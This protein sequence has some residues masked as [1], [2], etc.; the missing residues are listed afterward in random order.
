MFKFF[1]SKSITI[2]VLRLSGVIGQSGLLRSGL[3]SHA[4][5]K[6]ID[7]LFSGNREKGYYDMIWD[8]NNFTSGIYFIH[9]NIDNKINTQK[10]IL[11][12]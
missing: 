10:V 9:F 7:K 5:E 3:S 8:A 2:P 11:L 4:I 12:K 1:F 6:L